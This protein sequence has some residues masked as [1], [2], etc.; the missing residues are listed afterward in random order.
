[1]A[2][3]IIVAGITIPWPSHEKLELLA[4]GMG[5]IKT[6]TFQGHKKRK[7]QGKIILMTVWRMYSVVQ[8]E[9]LKHVRWLGMCLAVG[10]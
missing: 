2:N 6:F 5:M 10:S 1:M 7:L 4:V 3:A 9:K 8:D